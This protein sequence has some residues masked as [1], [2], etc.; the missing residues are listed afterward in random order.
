M[1]CLVTKG[2]WH[3]GFKIHFFSGDIAFRYI[4]YVKNSTKSQTENFDLNIPR[5]MGT[6]DAA[7]FMYEDSDDFADEEP[8]VETLVTISDINKAMLDVGRKKAENLGYTTGGL[9]T[10]NVYVHVYH[11]YL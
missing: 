5:S 6:G 2:P 8:E 10:S 3:Q 7:N 1:N 11:V 9:S 4:E